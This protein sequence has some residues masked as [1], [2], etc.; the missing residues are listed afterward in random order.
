M[1]QTMI[2]PAM[3]RAYA[4]MPEAFPAG[5]EDRPFSA[6]ATYNK[7]GV[8][9]CI[10]LLAA[11]AGWVLGS[12]GL[13]MGCLVVGFGAVL[14][15]TFKPAAAPV[16]APL[17]ALCEGVVLGWVSSAYATLGRGVVPVSVVFTAAVFAAAFAAFRSGLVRVTPRFVSV[18]LMATVGL[19]VVYLLAMVGLPVPGANDI[20]GKGVIFGLIGLGIAVMNLFVDFSFVEQ[21]EAGAALG[22]GR[23]RVALSSQGEWYA[24]QALMVSLVLVYLNVLRIVGA[25][26]G[27]GRR[28]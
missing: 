9:V 22:A 16:T 23:G 28:S 21:L 20:G 15:G 12:G 19:A 11:M 18:T 25:A 1:A 14:V 6:N 3:Q 8:L 4:R 2:K 27:G 26:A 17:Y 7:V 13:A 24:A 5:A 10:A